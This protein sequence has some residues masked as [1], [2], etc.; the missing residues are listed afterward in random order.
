[1]KYTMWPAHISTLKFASLLMTKHN[2]SPILSSRLK[3]GNIPK[4]EKNK[5]PYRYYILC[6]IHV[7]ASIFQHSLTGMKNLLFCSCT[8]KFQLEGT[9]QIRRAQITFS[10][11]TH[12]TYTTPFWG[13][14][15]LVNVSLSNLRT[16]IY[17]WNQRVLMVIG[18]VQ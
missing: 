5:K 11:N 1:M 6:S 7:K 3:Q 10:T 13:G 17:N 4:N 15:R 9:L 14:R 8:L 2:A 12:A 18:E 16:R